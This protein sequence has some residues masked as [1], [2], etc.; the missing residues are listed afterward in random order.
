[1]RLLELFSGI[2]SVGDVFKDHDWE[3]V[4]LDRDLPAYIN[5]DVL[6][7][8]YQNAYPPNHFDFI[9]ASPPC[10][11][12]SAA[13]TV[14]VRKLEE[15]N[16]LVQRTLDIIDYFQPASGWIMENPQTGLLKHQDCVRDL[17]YNDLDYCK[18]G[19]PYRKRT[20]LWNTLPNFTPRP[21]CKRDCE[22]I[23]DDGRHKE[24][25]QRGGRKYKN[26][27]RETIR[28]RQTDLYRVPRELVEEIIVSL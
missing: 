27:E 18:Y 9:W 26:G 17:P 24:V 16:G 2:G 1:M 8:D 12:Y 22:S 13:K 11:E 6:D 15:S 21:L 7:W 28:H 3:V 25:A 20:R 5:C 10:T 14:G 23:Q 19:M 4:S